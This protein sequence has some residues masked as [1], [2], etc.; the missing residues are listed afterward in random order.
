MYQKRRKVEN[1]ALSAIT[2]VPKIL[3]YDNCN[4]NFKKPIPSFLKI[5]LEFSLFY[6]QYC[7]TFRLCELFLLFVVNANFS[8]LNC[9]MLEVFYRRDF[10][11]RVVTS[12]SYLA[13]RWSIAITH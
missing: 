12:G 8:I 1:L 10:I 6:G 5:V 7:G 13:Y 3:Q 2:L 11:G 9:Y 4:V